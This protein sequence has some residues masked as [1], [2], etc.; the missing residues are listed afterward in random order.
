[1]TGRVLKSVGVG[2][3]AALLFALLWLFG[4]ERLVLTAHEV[5]VSARPPSFVQ[6]SGGTGGGSV[7]A[8]EVVA[9]STIEDPYFAPLTLGVFTVVS[10][11]TFRRL[12]VRP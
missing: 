10:I 2:F 4:L 8:D 11:W 3:A 9:E 6:A 12:R 1:M 7:L 5:P